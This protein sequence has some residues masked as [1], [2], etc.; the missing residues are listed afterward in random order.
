MEF[1]RPEYWSGKLFP[2]PVDLPNPGIKPRSP[3]LQANSLPTE[4]PGKPK[5]TGVVAYP[6]SSGSSQPRNWTGVSWIA[7]GFFT[8]WAIPYTLIEYLLLSHRKGWNNT[9]CSNMDG[10]RDYH[11]KWSKSDR[12]RQI[13]YDIPYIWNWKYDTSEV[14]YETETDAQT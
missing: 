14:I 10:T 5:N 1:S 7:R 13:P 12:E 3:T 2:S 8:N 4:L 11:T 9:F 6:F